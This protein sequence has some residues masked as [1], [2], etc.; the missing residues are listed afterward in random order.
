MLD[1]YYDG[2]VIVTS[3]MN[4]ISHNEKSN[5]LI[6]SAGV[7]N[8]DLSQAAL[9]LGLAGISWIHRLPGSVGGTVRMNARCY[10]GEI[11][12]VVSKVKTVSL[13]GKINEYLASNNIFRGYKDTVFMDN[14]DIVCEATIDLHS[15]NKNEI[16]QK[17]LH[18]ESDRIAKNR[19]HIHLVDV[20]L[21]Q[22]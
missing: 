4:S 1:D 7:E 21:K 6:V 8:S 9:N 3:K 2:H 12:E 15:G 20:S 13:D 18:C 17:M 19:S 22:L 5:Q 10:G 14:G 11:S 16:E